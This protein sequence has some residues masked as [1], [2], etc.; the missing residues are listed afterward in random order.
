LQFAPLPDASPDVR[1][2]TNGR[3]ST[4]RTK[5]LIRAVLGD[6]EDVWDELFRERAYGNYPHPTIVLVSR[7]ASS[8][9]GER[10]VSLVPFYCAP[11]SR[12]YTDPMLLEELANRSGDF[13]AAYVIAR[14][15]G[16]HV[17]AVLQAAQFLDKGAAPAIQQQGTGI[18]A[19]LDM[20]A[21][22]YAGAWTHFV[23]K[24]NQVDTRELEDGSAAAVTIGNVSNDVD[25]AARRLRA[26]RRGLSTGDPR[27]CD[28]A[29]LPG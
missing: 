12:I 13:A 22:C 24:R 5:D 10:D 15:V 28:L 17:Q 19:A 3:S 9:C 23:R 25:Y 2:Q 11:E 18:P 20:R 14:E 1:A 16:Q 21:D 29:A 8:A 6:T 4:E 26:F 7:W 27:S